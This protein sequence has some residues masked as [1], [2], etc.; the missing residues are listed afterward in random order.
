MLMNNLDPDVA[1]RPD[2]LV[3]YGGTGKAARTWEAFDAIVRALRALERRRDAARAERQA[4]RRVP[5]ARARAARADRQ[6]QPRRPLGDLGALP[7]AR[8][9]GPH[10]V[11]P[12]DRRLVD[13][14]RL[15]GHRAGHVRDVRR[16]GATSTSAARS[17]AASCVTAGLGGM[18]GAQPLAAT[19]NGA[20]VLGDRGRRVAHRQAPR[21]AATRPQDAVDSTRRWRG[22]REARRAATALSVGLVGNAADVL[23][24]LVRR[25]VT[26]D[27]LTD[28]TSAHDTLNGYVP[29]GHVA[30][31]GGRAARARSRR[32]TSR[33]VD[34]VD[35]R[36]RA[37][38]ARAA[39][40]AARSRSTTATTSAP[41]RSTP[42]STDAFDI[43]GFVPEYIRP[44]FCEG[45]GPFRWVAL[46]GDPDGHPPHRRAGARAV[47]RRR[48]PAALDHA[49][50]RA[51]RSSRDCR[52]ASAGWG[53]ASARGSASRS[54]TSSRSGELSRADR[55]RARPPRHR[56]RRVAVPRDRRR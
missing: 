50:A 39:A 53:R 23:P 32:S 9:A 43:P 19:M 12:D 13:L 38:D 24:E 37:R 27:V 40:S 25:G 33:A 45:K 34:G 18:G 8:A 55:D 29:D 22:S 47:S 52:R 41:S 54:T 1:E 30:R 49:R 36:A 5:H 6:L 51:D 44:L 26:P 35:R 16:G 11:R 46:S 15:A 42:A 4:G 17:R 3:V 21:D 7:R 48:A 56:Q 14:H 2:D 10:D 31:R 28:Q 20:A